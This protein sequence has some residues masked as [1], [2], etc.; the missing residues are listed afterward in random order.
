MRD[1]GY[2]PPAREPGRIPRDETRERRPKIP[3]RRQAS[4]GAPAKPASSRR[5]R[6]G[7]AAGERETRRASSISLSRQ[8]HRE[9]S[10]A[11]WHPDHQGCACRVARE[12]HF[13]AYLR[14]RSLECS[15][16]PVGFGL[17]VIDAYCLRACVLEPHL[18]GRAEQHRL[19][20]RHAAL[21]QLT[22]RVVGEREGV[23]GAIGNRAVGFT[24]ARSLPSVNA[25]VLIEGCQL[26]CLARSVLILLLERQRA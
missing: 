15:Y 8:L 12:Q 3:P 20:W 16:Q 5:C 26:A 10:K 9:H 19:E 11:Q 4:S 22:P 17:L 25:C 1:A 13:K 7:R 18:V 21:S 14:S 2:S 24:V 23:F 6:L